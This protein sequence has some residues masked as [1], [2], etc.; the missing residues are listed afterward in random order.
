MRVPV[1][2]EPPTPAAAPEPEMAPGRVLPRGWFGFGFQ[3]DNCTAN[4]ES[5]DSVAV[6]TFGSRPRVYLVTAGSP[7]ARAGLLRGDVITQIDGVPIDSE[8]GGRLFGNIRPG[9]S[10]RWTLQRGAAVRTAVATAEER[11]E[12][13][14][15]VRAYDQVRQALTRLNETTDLRRMR[16]ELERLN[17]RI[18]MLKVESAMPPMPVMRR[19]TSRQLRYAGVVGCTEVEVRGTS[20]VIVS[21]SDDKNEVVINTGESVVVIRVP[22]GARVEKKK[23]K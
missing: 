4:R 14:A 15:Q 10:V 8:E 1:A 19:V 2:P 22:P 12:R 21:E 20:G 16:V 11:P 18:A 5:N 9:Q 7:A 3:C 23:E 17:E 13:L 6:W